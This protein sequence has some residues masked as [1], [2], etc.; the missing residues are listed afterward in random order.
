MSNPL[1]PCHSRTYIVSNC[2][3]H[4]NKSTMKCD[5]TN[6]S[7]IH[8]WRRYIST[9]SIN[10]NVKGNIRYFVI[11]PEVQYQNI[12]TLLGQSIYQV[13]TITHTWYEF[14]FLYF[15]SKSH[16]NHMLNNVTYSTPLACL[17]TNTNAILNDD[18]HYLTL[19]ISPFNV[20]WFDLCMFLG[21]QTLWYNIYDLKSES[22]ISLVYFFPIMLIFLLIYYF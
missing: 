18:Y 17:P 11:I 16:F 5:I 10:T 21:R 13:H 2:I 9:I 8:G 20:Q 14:L 15:N 3:A 22:L 7:Y 1:E 6:S 12:N 4:I 19:P